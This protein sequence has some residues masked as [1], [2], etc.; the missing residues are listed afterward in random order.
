MFPNNFSD[1][2]TLINEIKCVVSID[3]DSL[4]YKTREEIYPD[5]KTS[6]L[7]GD[8][9]WNVIEDQL[10]MSEAIFKIFSIDKDNFKGSKKNLP[11]LFI[12]TI[13]H[14]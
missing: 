12:Q 7:G 4:V 3:G 13:L 6:F 10:H 11:S 8:W 1:L 14:M 5:Q 2:S 9:D